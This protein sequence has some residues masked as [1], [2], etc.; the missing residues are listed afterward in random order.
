MFYQNKTKR[1]PI[2]IEELLTPLALS[3]WYMDDGSLKSHQSKGIFLN[4]QSFSPYEN[5]MLCSI[6]QT[7]YQIQAWKRPDSSRFRIYI[8][9]KSYETFGSLITP[10]FTQDMWYKWPRAQKIRAKK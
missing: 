10:Y 1:V 7:K 6:L 4:T 5:D 3:I 9:G 8:S 2:N